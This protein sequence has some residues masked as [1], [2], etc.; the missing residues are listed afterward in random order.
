MVEGDKFKCDKC[1]G[2]GYFPPYI[3]SIEVG[4][5]LCDKCWGEKEL[6]WIENI[7]GKPCPWKKYENIIVGN[8]AGLN[9]MT[10]H[11]NIAIGYKSLSIKENNNVMIG[12]KAGY[13]NGA[14]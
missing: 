9:I 2:K 3:S 6:D 10:G 8:K 14:V 4:Q 7:V 5:K 13:R 11:K 12:Y 1:D